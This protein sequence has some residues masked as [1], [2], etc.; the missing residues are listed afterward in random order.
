MTITKGDLALWAIAICF[1]LF[2][3]FGNNWVA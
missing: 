1:L 3:L 2:L